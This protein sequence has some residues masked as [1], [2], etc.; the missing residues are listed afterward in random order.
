MCSNAV[1]ALDDGFQRLGISFLGIISAQAWCLDDDVDHGHGDLWFFLAGQGEQRDEAE[2]EGGD[3][4]E[5]CER[6]LMKARVRLPAMPRF[7]IG[8]SSSGSPPPG[9]L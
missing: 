5:R 9:G 2:G 3:Q 8:V 6:D 1:D 7:F 4:E